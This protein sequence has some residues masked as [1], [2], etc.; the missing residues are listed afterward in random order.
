MQ[1]FHQGLITLLI[2][3]PGLLVLISLLVAAAAIDA[4]A[5]RIPNALTIGGALAAVLLGFAQPQPLAGWAVLAAP[6]GWLLGLLLT[7]PLYLARALGGGDVKLIAMVGAFVGPVHTVTV[8]LS[9]F[10]TG[11][12]L[13]LIRLARQRAWGALFLRLHSGAALSLGRMPYALSIC[14]G[15]LLYV[16]VFEPQGLQWSRAWVA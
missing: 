11:G 15:T 12:V 10:I 13:A 16:G 4:Y 9:I 2:D 3:Q 8:V 5:W 1:T 14:V 6:A 7:L